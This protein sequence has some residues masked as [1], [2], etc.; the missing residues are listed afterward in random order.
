MKKLMR[1]CQALTLEGTYSPSHRCLKRRG[2]QKLG[3]QFLCAHHR[4]AAQRARA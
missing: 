3:A 1:Q 2:I 4:T